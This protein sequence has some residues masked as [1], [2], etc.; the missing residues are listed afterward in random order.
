MPS[1]TEYLTSHLYVAYPFREDATGL[2][3]S[4][5]GT[6]G[7]AAILPMAA[8]ADAAAFVPASTT[9]LYLKS[10]TDLGSSVYRCVVT[11]Q[12]GQTI[13]TLDINALAL[14]PDVAYSVVSSTSVEPYIKLVV[15]T[16]TLLAYLAGCTADTF[17][18]G[19]PFEYRTLSPKRPRLESI[20]VSNS[21][22]TP[23]TPITGDIMFVP[24]YNSAYTVEDAQNDAT[25]ITLDLAAGGGEGLYP[26]TSSTSTVNKR[27]MGLVPDD[28]GNIN[29][30]GGDENCYSIIP[31]ALTQIH[32]ACVAC[33]SCEDYANV[34]KALK[35]LLNKADLTLKR[36]NEGRDTYESGVTDFNDPI[37]GRFIGPKLFASGYGGNML[38]HTLPV[39]VIPDDRHGARSSSIGWATIS[40]ELQNNSGHDIE[41]RTTGLSL[42]PTFIEK[43]VNWTYNGAGGQSDTFA[44][45]AAALGTSLRIARGKTLAATITLRSDNANQD[46]DPSWAGAV[47]MTVRVYTALTP[48]P[49][50]YDVNLTAALAFT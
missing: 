9:A 36:L 15:H 44:G 1:G 41:V 16:T 29:I 32:G 27:C 31:G 37:A 22:A 42:T 21:L 7:S 13:I 25:E 35:N 45:L 39:P 40:V 8:I 4:N 19:L 5:V 11:N 6:H 14:D 34:A 50:H 46:Y 26:C 28:S 20:A 48:V 47:T 49:V 43:G 2:D 3:R 17:G 24:G 38:F 23:G 10:I 33:C 30:V 12:L 18:T